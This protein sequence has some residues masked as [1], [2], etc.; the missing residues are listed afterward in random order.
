MRMST[1]FCTRMYHHLIQLLDFNNNLLHDSVEIELVSDEQKDL[2][3]Q[4]LDL[5]NNWIVTS[6]RIMINAK[7]S[8]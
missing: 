5:C 4:L 2:R 6:K 7:T 1:R 3:Q 8:M